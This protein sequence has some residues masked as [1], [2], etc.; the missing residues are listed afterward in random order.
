MAEEEPL[1]PEKALQK[2]RKDF[3]EPPNEFRTVPFWV[4]NGVIT[5]EMIDEQLED[6]KLHGMGGVLD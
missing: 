4:W 5:E 6:M 3:A 2:L 1:D